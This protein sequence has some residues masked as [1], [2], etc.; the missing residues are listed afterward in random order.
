[1]TPKID[2]VKRF[3]SVMEYFRTL[4]RKKRLRLIDH[5]IIFISSVY[6]VHIAIAS[7]YQMLQQEELSILFLPQIHF[8]STVFVIVLAI[9]MCEFFIRKLIR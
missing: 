8:L 6:L 1:M 5:T 7:W 9:V 4:P 3:L 2:P